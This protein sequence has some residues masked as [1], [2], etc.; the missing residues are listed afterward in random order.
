GREAAFAGS[1][2]NVR[3]ILTIRDGEVVPLKRVRGSGKALAAFGAARESTSS[4]EPSLRVGI[5]HAAAPERLRAL[6]ELVGQVR[7]RAVL[8]VATSLGAV[9]GTHA[10][11][12]TVGFFWFD[13]IE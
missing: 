1:L 9:V 2:L 13:D 4:D 3:P 7:P 11:P 5:A 10:G 12:G 6:E 8:E